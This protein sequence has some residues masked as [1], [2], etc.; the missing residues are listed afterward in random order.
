MEDKLCRA[1]GTFAGKGILVIGDLMLDEYVWGRVN[2]ISPEAPIP[3]VDVN[4]VTYTPGGACNVAVNVAS[5]GGKAHLLG[6]IGNDANGEKLLREVGIRSVDASAVVVDSTRPTTLK[7]RII[8]H[9]QQ[10]VR[11]DWESRNPLPE[12][13][14][15]LLFSEVMRVLPA[16]DV[17]VISD[18]AKGVTVPTFVQNVVEQCRKLG[19]K[20]VVDPKGNDYSKYRGATVITPNALE[21]AQAAQLDITDD[22]SL[23]EAGDRLLKET[24]CDAVLITRGEKGMSV[25]EAKGR[26]THLPTFARQVYDVT[27]AGDTVIAALAMSLAADLDMPECAN[28]ANHAA[29]VVVGKVGTATVSADE[30]IATLK[31]G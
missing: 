2:R 15:S 31:R 18:Y 3:V 14:I 12:E 19:I 5:L 13:T 23:G 22:Y 25:F 16:I 4:K 11:A 28:L 24:T 8:A 30:L 27:G 7:S 6:V 10:I 9:N 21:A 17:V 26:I 29:S 1:I 20:V